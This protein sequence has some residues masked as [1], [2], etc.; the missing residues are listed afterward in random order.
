MEQ[1]KENSLYSGPNR[2]Q[3]L[4]EDKEATMTALIIN[5]FGTL[6]LLKIDAKKVK[7]RRIL[8]SQEQLQIG[9]I[10][11]THNDMVLVIRL[12]VDAG[13]IPVPV[14]AQMIRLL[15]E[16]RRKKAAEHADIDDDQLRE[17][18]TKIHWRSNPPVTQLRATVLDFF[19]GLTT[20]EEFT[21]RLYDKVFENKLILVQ[22]AMEFFP[23]ARQ[24]QGLF[25]EI[26]R[27]SKDW[28]EVDDGSDPE[29]GMTVAERID[30]MIDLLVDPKTSRDEVLSIKNRLEFMNADRE[31]TEKI[32]AR[33]VPSKMYLEAMEPSEGYVSMTSGPWSVVKAL[34]DAVFQT[35]NAVFAALHLNRFWSDLES[36]TEGFFSMGNLK[37]SFDERV[38][39]SGV[40]IAGLSI[41]DAHKMIGDAIRDIVIMSIVNAKDIGAWKK[42]KSP[43]R[44]LEGRDYTKPLKLFDPDEIHKTIFGL[45]L[46]NKDTAMVF[47]KSIMGGI[48]VIHGI[49]PYQIIVSDLKRAGVEIDHDKYLIKGVDVNYPEEIGFLNELAAEHGGGYSIDYADINKDDE[50]ASLVARFGDGYDK[51]IQALHNHFQTY[52]DNKTEDPNDPFAHLF[53][54]GRMSRD[55]TAPE[56]AVAFFE[57]LKK[58]PRLKDSVF[59]YTKD[60]LATRNS[61]INDQSAGFL[62][63][64]HKHLLPLM[65]DV[66]MTKLYRA[67][68]TNRDEATVITS[69]GRFA[70]SALGKPSDINI[71]DRGD[72]KT[73]SLAF[74]DANP[75]AVLAYYTFDVDE[76]EY[77]VQIRLARNFLKAAATN[78]GLQLE[79]FMTRDIAH[80]LKPEDW[81][82]LLTVF[83]SLEGEVYTNSERNALVSKAMELG[84]NF[85][86][87][88]PSDTMAAFLIGTISE[89]LDISDYKN[90]VDGFTDQQIKDVTSAVF[91]A[92]VGYSNIWSASTFMTRNLQNPVAREHFIKLF[93]ESDRKGAVRDNM[94]EEAIA[95]FLPKDQYLIGFRMNLATSDTLAEK[96]SHVSTS[97]HFL[98][99]EDV[100]KEDVESVLVKLSELIQKFDS[101]D[102]GEDVYEEEEVKL[103]G[104]AFTA[105]SALEPVIERF[106]ESVDAAMTAVSG[107]PLMK[108][109]VK[110]LAQSNIVDSLSGPYQ[111]DTIK[112]YTEQTREEILR[113]MRFNKIDVGTVLGDFYDPKKTLTDNLKTA[114]SANVTL[115]PLKVTR[116]E[117]TED[118]LV[119]ATALIEGYNRHAHSGRART[120]ILVL[121]MFD[122]SIPQQHAQWPEFTARMERNKL[123]NDYMKTVFHGTGSV[124]AS[125]ILRYG[126]TIPEFD[127]DAGMSGRA[128][129]DGV[130]FTDVS[131]KASLYIG[132][133]GYR[134]GKVGYLFEMDA[135]LGNPAIKNSRPST[136]TDGPVFNHRSGGFTDATN[137]QDFISPEWAVF[138]PHAQVR[139]RR[140]YEVRIVDGDLIEELVKGRVSY[141]K[142]LDEAEEKPTSFKEFQ[143]MEAEDG[144]EGHTAT[145]IFADG[146]VP[147]GKGKAVPW[148]KAKIKGVR[149]E[150]GQ[151]GVIISV[152]SSR[153]KEDTVYRDCSGGEFAL[154]SAYG[155]YAYHLGLVK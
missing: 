121:R 113:S 128:L 78:E 47:V 146:M 104:I 84:V 122:V 153:V 130:Y 66:D 149:I 12:G 115:E 107:S 29:A 74:H 7:A 88:I 93:Q 150:S 24:Y 127:G 117:A 11:E 3:D 41:I 13:I 22:Y 65:L 45:N 40:K 86:G 6:G 96:L 140:A 62:V 53:G 111:N 69:T 71:M 123:P 142:L 52:R 23:M 110:S 32:I 70:F 58:H 154:S 27:N 83:T 17:W 118:Q 49:S 60:V 136:D 18:L 91:N 75:T 25:H 1:L 16:L 102:Q 114:K 59:K 8:N 152:T 85:D 106:P 10:A 101:G 109:V 77:D 151:Q 31:I 37:I 103:D 20:L 43:I 87:V 134:G 68:P 81:M 108:E 33:T 135:Q 126:F 145:Y 14:A 19:E 129:G 105:T 131:D 36:V 21:A 26:K 63:N 72:A 4:V 94:S 155:R 55:F 79:A 112:P 56:E 34:D 148:K 2:R 100:T 5:F 30:A 137:H 48:G 64:L 82:R 80:A 39:N 147:V 15:R 46:S 120:G 99:R 9:K 138:D 50:W 139:I 38:I 51:F 67:S 141:Q 57:S 61:Y 125:M 124:A 42:I 54:S 116:V 133:A 98:K 89:G 97:R 76:F 28:N 35:L 73:L 44:Y 92:F 90:S 95:G 119:E 132:D 143:L 144:K